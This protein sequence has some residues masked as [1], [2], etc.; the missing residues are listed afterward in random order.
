M[1]VIDRPIEYESRTEQFRAGMTRYLC[2]RTLLSLVA[3]LLI[4]LA[5]LIV[6]ADAHA[7]G[8][9][10]ARPSLVR[11]ISVDDTGRN[12]EAWV[13]NA[14]YHITL[15]HWP[16]PAGKWDACLCFRVTG[17]TERLPLLVQV[18][19]IDTGWSAWET[20]SGLNQR[21]QWYV[22]WTD[23][24]D[25]LIDGP[26]WYCTRITAEVDYAQQV[27]NGGILIA[28]LYDSY[29]TAG[30]TYRIAASEIFVHLRAR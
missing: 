21:G 11:R 20:W 4:V 22:P 15:M 28:S 14:G 5:S 12:G 26:G 29:P 2:N 30:R 1:R 6:A 27:R 19:A 13:S 16:W 23:G 25:V 10:M 7:D 17:P 18:R 3:A 8:Y 9:R 24:Y